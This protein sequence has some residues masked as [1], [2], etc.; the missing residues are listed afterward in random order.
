MKYRISILLA[1]AL[2]A[3]LTYAEVPEPLT[4][5]DVIKGSVKDVWAAFTTKAGQESWMVSHSEIDLKVGGMMRTQ[6]AKEGKI[7]DPNTINNLIISF[8]PE[9]MFSI[10]IDKPPVRF[11]WKK[12]AQSTWT[13]IY[14]EPVS[15]KET[16]VTVRMLG[17]TDDDE[18]RA[19]RKF[20]ESGNKQTLDELKAHFAKK[21]AAS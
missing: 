3:S 9:R 6:Y 16:K 4:H 7:G 15:D 8:D 19:M 5:S 11:P 14:F 10:K 18:S 2:L 21:T 13:V 1:G 20:F 17:W 12:A